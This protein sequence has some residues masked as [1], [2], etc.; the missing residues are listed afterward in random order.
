MAGA[1]GSEPDPPDAGP[2]VPPGPLV[3]I[4]GSTVDPRGIPRRVLSVLDPET[5]V[6]L[7][8]EDLGLAGIVYD[9]NTDLWYLFLSGTYPAPRETPIDMQVRRWQGDTWVHVAS[10]PAIPPPAAEQFAV[11]NQRLAYAS[12][13]IGPGNVPVQAI[14][15]FDTTDPTLLVEIPVPAEVV[16]VDDL[17]NPIIDLIGTPGRPNDARAPGGDLTLLLAKSCRMG[18]TSTTCEMAAQPVTVGTSISRGVVRSFGLYTGRPAVTHAVSRDLLL[19]ARPQASPLSVVLNQFNART[20]VEVSTLVTSTST[21]Q[22]VSGVAYG[23]CLDAA[24][25]VEGAPGAGNDMSLFAVSLVNALGTRDSLGRPGE[26]AY[27]EPLTRTLIAPYRGE[28]VVN[29]GADAGADAGAPAPAEIVA[30]RVAASGPSV[31]IERRRAPNWQPPVGL[32]VDTLAVRRPRNF[33][34]PE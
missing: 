27:F 17:S 29:G 13:R 24:L 7:A 10:V 19:V 16:T 22:E 23:D 5:G 18:A 15:I 25:F 8:R 31:A 14:T 12:W 1:S 3:V 30:Y 21:T 9:A 20:L 26:G 33:N 34:C 6:E 2:I 11:L 32:S 4:G 28:P